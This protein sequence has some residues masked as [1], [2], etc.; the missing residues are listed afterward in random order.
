VWV[1]RCRGDGKALRL[2]C[3]ICGRGPVCGCGGG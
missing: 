2:G 3:W 1:T